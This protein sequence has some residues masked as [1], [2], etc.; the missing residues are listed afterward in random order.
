MKLENVKGTQD[1]MPEEKIALNTIIDS[2]RESFELYGYNPLETPALE[3]LDVLASKFAGGEEILKEIY[4]LSDQGGRE[5]ALRYDLTVPFARVVAM[6][7]HVK[8]P[9]KRYQIDKVW[10][11]GPIK[12][13]RYR[14]FWQCDCDVVGI[15]S[16]AAEAEL[17]AMARGFFENLGLEVTLRVNNRALLSDMMKFAG[18]SD[19][20]SDSA[21]LSIDKLLKIGAEGVEKELVEKGLSKEVADKVIDI[22]SQDFAGIEKLI[23]DSRGVAE[24]KELQTLCEDFG[25]KI[26]LDPTLARGLAYYTGTIYEV[27]VADGS[28]GS[29]IAA[30]GR[31]DNMITEFVGDGKEYPCVG[32]SFGLSAIKDALKVKELLDCKKS[33]VDVLVVSMNE[34]AFARVVAKELRFA[35]VNTEVDYLGRSISKNLD[36]ANKMGIRFVAIV[37]ENEAK[38]EKVTLKDMEKGSQELLSVADVVNVVHQ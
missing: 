14:E 15:A 16:V 33:V 9:F 37:G 2:L 12:L 10:R 18:V 13:G 17:L 4:K 27:F 25:V 3:Y 7:P 35:G 31:Y 8:K 26:T 11:D 19:D 5:L 24:L 36:F 28:F 38:D 1:I 32:I 20:M 34:D 21:V 22:I 6:N 30:G 29:A 23:P